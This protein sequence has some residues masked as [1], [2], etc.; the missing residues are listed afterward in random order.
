MRHQGFRRGGFIPMFFGMVT[1]VLVS[2]AAS[3]VFAA[4]DAQANGHAPDVAGTSSGCPEDTTVQAARAL[5]F[6]GSDDFWRESEYTVCRRDPDDPR[7]AIVAF[8][9]FS[10]EEL[11]GKSLERD[12]DE[13]NLDLVIIEIPS[14]KIIAHR[15]EDK[16]LQDDA[17][18][19]EGI[20]IDT[21]RY[22][23]APGKRAFGIRASNSTHCTCANS[24]H[25]QLSLYLPRGDTLDS[26]MAT[27]V[28][29][30]QA[31][32]EKDSPPPPAC[33][34][35][36]TTSTTTIAVGKGKSHVLADLQLTTAD[37]SEYGYDV[38][39]SSCPKLVPIKH[40]ETFRYDGSVYKG[41]HQ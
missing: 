9:Y 6:G 15:H 25:T 35:V 36:A 11:T 32:Y 37:M 16:T 20:S 13:R 1:F 33:S 10:G 21:G 14:G 19:L 8:A 41:S 26:V 30:Y 4:G 24:S 22:I 39:T 7:Q 28:Y 38:N 5:H 3:P 40:T 27:G 29:S 34:S 23:L 18:R 12:G 17:E 31:E 2:G